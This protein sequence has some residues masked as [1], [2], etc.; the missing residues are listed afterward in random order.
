MLYVFRYQS[1][2]SGEKDQESPEMSENEDCDVVKGS[3]RREKVKFDISSLKSQW[4]Q[5]SLGG[6]KED[7]KEEQRGELAAL[8]QKMCLGRS[9]SM[10]QVYERACK[11][12]GDVV[13]SE[14]IILDTPVKTNFIKEKFEKGSFESEEENIERLRRERDEEL[15]LF[16][17]SETAA[18]EARNM[19]KQIDANVNKAPI[20]V[21]L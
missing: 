17:E 2:V 10:R 14:S 13:R 16:Q 9:E 11:E 20:R 19:F 1:A 12:N 15:S 5:G 8:R 4:E 6:P 18:K 7:Y 3:A 21:L